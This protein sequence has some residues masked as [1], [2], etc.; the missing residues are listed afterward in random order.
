[1]WT[2][3]AS[4]IIT[5][6]MKAE[7]G[8]RAA[9]PTLVTMR[10]AKLQLSRAGILAQAEAAIAAMEGQPAEEA[11]IEWEYATELRRDHPLVLGIGQALGLDDATIDRLFVEAAK[12]V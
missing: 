3:D 8:A 1:M 11:Q 10:Q 9:I 12:I 2:P 4:D 7:E 6:E 5:A